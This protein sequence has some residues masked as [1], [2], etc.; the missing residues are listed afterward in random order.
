MQEHN[1]LND[2][3]QG[4]INNNR[5][6]QKE[7]YQ[8]FYGYAAALCMRYCSNDDDINQ[9]VNDG[10]LKVY[11]SLHLF[12]PQY[13]N[14]EASLKGWIKRIMIN[15]AIDHLRKNNRHF[16]KA[17]IGDHQENIAD[18]ST[19]SIDRMGYKEILAIIQ[20][21]TPAY[22]TVFNLYVMDGF[23]HE[24]IAKQL[25]ITVGAS[26]S[27]LA[28]ARINIQKMLKETDINYYEQKAV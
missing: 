28:K 14:V 16:L 2:I 8:F 15:T 4:C 12:T 18:E 3:I 23:K 27:N 13:A 21:L 9:V 1:R 5:G 6:S 22:R 26:K 11:K 10:F 19:T 7:F 20:K 24:E 25:K 17:E